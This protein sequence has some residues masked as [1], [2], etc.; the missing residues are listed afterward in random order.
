MEA[1]R[2]G[3]E[4][5]AFAVVAATISAVAVFLPLVFLS[6]MTGQLFRE[7]AVTVASAIAISGFVAVTLSPMLSARVLRHRKEETGVKKVLANGINAMTAGYDRLLRPV[8][9][10]PA[11]ANAIVFFGIVWV[12]GGVFLYGIAEQELIPDGDRS[13]LLAWT[14]APEGATVDYMARYQL[15]AEEIMMGLEEQ[16]GVLS[17][18]ALGIGTPGDVNQGIVL[19]QLVPRSERERSQDEIK[20][21]IIDPLSE[22]T[23]IKAFPIS[24]SPMRG[25][26]S[27]PIE[28]VIT[29]PDLFEL[30]RIAD[31][32]ER[33]AKDTGL[34]TRVRSD[35]VLNKPQ[36][37]V[38]IDRDRA[39]DLGMSAR[40]MATTLQILLGGVDISTFKKD[41]ETYDVIAQLRPSERT[42]A[43]NVM[44]LF[45]RGHSGLIP[46]AAVVETKLG[47]APRAVPHYDRRRSVTL[48]SALTKGVSQDVGLAKIMEIAQSKLPAAGGYKAQYSGEAEKFF[49]SGDSLLFAYGLAILIVFLVLA[50]Q[51]E[52]FMYP[53]VILVAVFLSFTGAL[54]ALEACEISLNLFSKIGIVMLVGLVTKNSILIVEFANQLRGRGESLE[55]A[56]RNAARTRFRPIVMTSLATM[57]GILPI[58]VGWG[59]GG[60]TR[61]GLGVAVVGGMFFSTILTFFVVPATYLSLERARVVVVRAFGGDKE[62][63]LANSPSTPPQVPQREAGS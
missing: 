43:R 37:E 12:V 40:D 29:G 30:A 19:T 58:A 35:L 63:P 60:S 38:S 53:L 20:E 46:L 52:S 41:G 8:V 14:S 27:D 55:D 2:K 7:F 39:N 9:E 10:K 42:N 50:A 59:A 49:E 33:D 51:F 31:E 23:G 1:A 54:V 4:E 34:F 21:S 3:M 45:V 26:S 56:V 24:P 5:I 18:I 62:E 36:L 16:G 17:V 48:T 13:F 57:F 6:D 61:M 32:V 28:I 11:L 25:F 15:Q 47:T 44:E 22:I